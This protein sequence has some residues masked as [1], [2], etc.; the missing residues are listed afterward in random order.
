MRRVHAP[1]RNH[2]D[3]TSG[4]ISG[5]PIGSA[6]SLSCR[7]DA[8][9]PRDHA[10]PRATGMRVACACRWKETET[11]A[12]PLLEMMMGVAPLLLLVVAVVVR[13]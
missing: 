2:F 3:G 11:M 10:F 12:I 1:G 4:S 5:R 6:G 8:T 13:P 9:Y 7:F